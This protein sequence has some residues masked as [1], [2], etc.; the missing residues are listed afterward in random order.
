VFEANAGFKEIGIRELK[1]RF[2]N[3]SLS[4]VVVKIVR[5]SNK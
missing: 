4:I 2:K 1:S 3:N 5:N